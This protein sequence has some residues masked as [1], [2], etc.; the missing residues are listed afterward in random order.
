MFLIIIKHRIG[1]RFSHFWC[2]SIAFSFYAKVSVSQEN[3]ER[4]KQARAWFIMR[5]GKRR[6]EA[7]TFSP[8]PSS[9]ERLLYKNHFYFARKD[10]FRSPGQLLCKF[11]GTK[12]SFFTRK[13]FNPRPDFCST[14]TWSSFH[15]FVPAPIKPPLRD[16]KMFLAGAS[17]EEIESLAFDMYI[18]SDHVE[19]RKMKN[20]TIIV[21]RLDECTTFLAII[22][23][24]FFQRRFTLISQTFAFFFLQMW[25]SPL[26]SIKKTNKKEKD[27]KKKMNVFFPLNTST[28]RLWSE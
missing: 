18:A 9:P 3:W 27:S 17:V 26:N 16:V 12:E 19:K 14:P 11:L 13:E 10:R 24:I 4:R 23:P 28:R 8:F 7:S 5:R 15:C 22:I 6:N 2:S 1:S 21:L 25:S 20:F